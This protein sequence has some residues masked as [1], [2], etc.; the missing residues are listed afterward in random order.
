MKM[1]SSTRSSVVTLIEDEVH[2]LRIDA[3]YLR[4]HGADELNEE[5]ARV[6]LSAAGA[7]HRLSNRLQR[8]AGLPAA[9]W[10]NQ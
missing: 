4:A 2:D 7:I 6:L 10:G 3:A 1:R 9:V 5:E 8:L